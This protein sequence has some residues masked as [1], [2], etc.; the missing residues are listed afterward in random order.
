MSDHEQQQPT[1]QRG[2]VLEALTR[3]ERKI[4]TRPA[5]NAAN[6][7]VRFLLTRAKESARS[8]ADPCGHLE[9]DL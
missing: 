4:F 1:P 3:A 9:F 8:L 6:A 5:P 2:K 7:Q